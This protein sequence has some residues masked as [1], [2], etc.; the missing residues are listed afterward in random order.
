MVNVPIEARKVFSRST[1]VVG[2][3][4]A[5]AVAEDRELAHRAV[6]DRVDDLAVDRAGAVGRDLVLVAHEHVV[7]APVQ[8]GRD[9]EAAVVRVERDPGRLALAAERHH[10][11]LEGV[12]HETVEARV[13]RLGAQL[14]RGEAGRRARPLDPQS[15]ARRAAEGER[16]RAIVGEGE[17]GAG[18]LRARAPYR[19]LRSA[20][21][22]HELALQEASDLELDQIVLARGVALARSVHADPGPEGDVVL[23]RLRHRRAHEGR[24]ACAALRPV[25][26][27]APG[28]RAYGLP[29]HLLGGEGRGGE[30]AG[31]TEAH[32]AVRAGVDGDTAHWIPSRIL[33]RAGRARLAPFA[34]G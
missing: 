24:V 23:E 31:E 21:R 18:L 15:Q 5:V 25:G 12:E 17:L 8:L 29:G 2:R 1:Q 14:E 28:D 6:L 22:Q 4:A 13:A 16:R 11:A 33:H 9:H 34:R 26:G 30:Q 3:A 32:G 27:Q 7:A 19:E 20:A 10:Q